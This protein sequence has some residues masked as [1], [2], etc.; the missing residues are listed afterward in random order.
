MEC[1]ASHNY[2]VWSK[3]LSTYCHLLIIE[4]KS[5]SHNYTFFSVL[6]AVK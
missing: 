1:V 5:P 6:E 3:L 4:Y 2:M